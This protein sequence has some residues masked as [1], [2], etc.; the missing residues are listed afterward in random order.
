MKLEVVCFGALNVDKLY[1]VDKIAK[2]EE[3]SVIL[4]FKEAPGGSAA[5]TAVGLARLG[6]KIGY[7]GKV[8]EDREGSI[9]LKSFMD[10]G[11]DTSGIIVSKGGRSG[12]V[13]GFVDQKGNRALYLDPGVNDALRFEEIDLR[14]FEDVKFLHLTSFVGEMP[15]EAQKKILQA[16]P[17]VKVTFDPGIIYARKG[18]DNLKPIIERCYAILPNENEVRI[19]TGKNYLEGAKI[20]LEEGAKI[21]AI[22]L[23]ERGCYVTD[24][25][26]SHIIEAFKVKVVDTTGA[27]D[28]FCAGFIYGLLKDKSLKECGILGNFVASRCLTKMG[29]R[30]GLPKIID[31]PTKPL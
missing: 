30:E 1:K 9:L 6:V 28:A 27:G 15:F 8:A 13:I 26:E 24:G 16:V 22:K 21:V 23:G 11:V 18:L 5:N 31:I 17:D 10:E 25:R 4:D 19:L 2:A 14:Y 20:L 7:I 12:S 3:E 29:A